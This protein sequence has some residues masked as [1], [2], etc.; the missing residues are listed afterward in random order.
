MRWGLALLAVGASPALA[1]SGNMA[2]ANGMASA[3]IV[4]PIAVTSVVDLDFGNVASDGD[5]AGPGSVM[6]GG[7]GAARYEGRARAVCD[8]GDCPAPHSAGFT[9]AGE[10]GRA[11]TITAPMFLTIA[12]RAIVGPED[13]LSV[14]G[15]MPQMVLVDSIA[16]RTASR[17]D[18]GPS[19]QLDGAGRDSFEIGGR[20]Q[21]PAG[22][23]PARYVTVIKVV[24]AYS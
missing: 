7:E 3:T 14:M 22:L 1:A 17:P 5:Q 10:A 6:L 4:E 15:T 20:L 23:P 13:A 21:L 19:G 24:V 18:D 9:V 16:V 12:P 2:T 11:Y 8:L